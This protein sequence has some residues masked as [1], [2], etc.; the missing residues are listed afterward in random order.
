[1]GRDKAF[2]LAG[3][4]PL[5]AIAREA[6]VGAGADEVMAIGGDERGLA[7]LG[8][9]FVPDPRPGDGPLGGVVTALE[10][11]RNDVV[12]VLACD[13]PDV[14]SPAVV[15]LVAALGGE[16]ADADAVLPFVDGRPQAL[17]AAYR[18]SCLAPFRS[19]F[20]AGERAVRNALPMVGVRALVLEDPGWARNV[21]RPEDLAAAP[22]PG[23]LRPPR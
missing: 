9:S 1:M 8:F 2:V 3:G 17:L 11:A 10:A 5:A 18:R 6:L 21:N 13:L 12:V 23:R 15:Q 22:A 20:E 7:T 14:R 16:D 19:A 4:L